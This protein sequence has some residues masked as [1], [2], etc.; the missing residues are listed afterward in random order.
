LDG[1]V[2]RVEEATL[3]PD[4]G[5]GWF[6]VT[7]LPDPRAVGERA[8]SAGGSVEVDDHGRLRALVTPRQLINAA[9]R[10]DAALGRELESAVEVTVEDWLAPPPDVDLPS[11]ARLR[12]SDRAQ[13]MGIV[14]VTPDSFSD[15]GAAYAPATHPTPAIEHARALLAAG[16]DLLDVGGESTRPGADPVP[17]DEELRRVIPVIEVL[18]GDGTIVS[19]DTTKARVAREAVAAGAAFVNDVSAGSL[20]EDLIPTVAELGV[21]YVLMH[22]RGTPRTMQD[23]PRYDDVVAEVYEYLAAG[24]DRLAVAGI[25]PGRVLVDP[26]IGFGKSAEHNLALLRS[27]R[28][29]TGLGRPVV[30]GTSRKSFI[31]KVTGVAEPAGR[32][33]GSVATAVL[34][35]AAGAGVVR[36]HDV[37]ETRQALA[38]VAALR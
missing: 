5:V 29:F 15:G 10:A 36:V 12:C 34:A 18:A 38:M 16:A 13:V 27:L 17:V 22:M 14:N 24:L 26:G 28:Q 4:G 31:G 11:G 20:D 2:V 3:V 33:A 19:V 7:G 32:V 21:P 25:P 9:G 6:V 1:L 30:I 8:A 23:D 35:A 37:A